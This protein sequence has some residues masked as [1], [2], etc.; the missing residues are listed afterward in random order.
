MRAVYFLEHCL[1]LAYDKRLPPLFAEWATTMAA[2]DATI[3][4][5]DDDA[6]VRKALA[7]LFQAHGYRVESYQS[8][9]DYLKHAAVSDKPSCMILDL[10]MP[11]LG[12]LD[13]QQELARREPQRQERKQLREL[14]RRYESLTNREKEVF[15][16]VV[17]G[18]LNK[19]IAA[20]LGAAEKTIKVHRGRVMTKMKAKSVA[21]LVRMAGRL[22]ISS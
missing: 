18:L 8:A 21:D 3:L 9:D 2:Q 19:Q 22:G 4:V 13:L 6:S 11:G 16:R 1:P 20:E 12:G 10:S 14:R 17:A 15:E 7:R 5:V